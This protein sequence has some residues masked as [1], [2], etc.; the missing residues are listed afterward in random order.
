VAWSLFTGVNHE[1]HE[2]TKIT[3]KKIFI[4]G[5]LSAASVLTD[6]CQ[7]HGRR[8]RPGKR[9]VFFVDFVFFVAFVAVAGR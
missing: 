4:L 3:K 8:K 1:G 6:E 7:P 9:V 5:V 2:D